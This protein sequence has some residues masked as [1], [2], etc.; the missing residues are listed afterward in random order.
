MV[1]LMNKI[2]TTGVICIL[3]G[4]TLIPI[5]NSEF[6]DKEVLI[7]VSTSEWITKEKDISIDKA[8]KLSA[9]LDTLLENPEEFEIYLPLVLKEMEGLGLIK[10]V[11]LME[12][13]IVKNVRDPQFNQQ[14]KLFLNAFCF[15]TGKSTNSGIFSLS[16]LLTVI[17]TRMISRITQYFPVI[18]NL[19][20]IIAYSILVSL[21][22]L[23]RIFFPFGI[24]HIGWEGEISTLGLLG[25]KKN[26]IQGG[27]WGENYLIFGFTGLWITY[28]MEDGY[29]A[30]WFIGSTIAVM[31]K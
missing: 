31:G 3:F 11:T 4:T 28:D 5:V 9:M 16:I 7:R 10:N 24:W 22:Y 21:F 25:H 2:L 19:T 6:S 26:S 18:H 30:N 12:Q 20:S 23:P 29:P 27:K 1:D 15:I 8:E 17:F 13:A 14:D